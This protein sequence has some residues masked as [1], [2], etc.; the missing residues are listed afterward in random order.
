[1]I[2]APSRILLD[3]DRVQLKRSERNDGQIEL[4]MKKLYLTAKLLKDYKPCFNN[5]DPNS[6]TQYATS[7]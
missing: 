2:K 4:S 6:P 1:M 5:E 7:L 3:G